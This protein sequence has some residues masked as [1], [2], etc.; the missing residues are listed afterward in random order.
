MKIL[1]MAE[2]FAPFVGGIETM[3]EHLLL[4]LA[5]QGHEICI[6]TSHC[7]AELPDQ[8]DWHGIPLYRLHMLTSL[9]KADIRGILTARAQLRA[10]KRDFAPD[11]AH[12]QFSGPSASFHWDTQDGA[13]VPTVVTI[14]SVAR[15]VVQKRSLFLDTMHNADWIAPVS[16]HMLDWTLGHAP[17]IADHASVVYNGIPGDQVPV[18]PVPLPFDPPCILWI[19]RMVGWKRV[20]RLIDAFAMLCEKPCNARLVL[21]GDGPERAALQARVDAAGLAD[22]V[23]FTGWVD[24]PARARLLE[25]ATLVAIPSQ[26]DENLPM[27]ALEAAGHGRPIAGSAVSGLPEIVEDGASGLLLPDITPASLAGAI[28]AIMSDPVSAQAM[29]ARARAIVAQRFSCSAM[30]ENYLAIYR[31]IAPAKT[32]PETAE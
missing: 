22:R 31:R 14:H 26:A 6:V 10:I 25:Q 21:A 19:G 17:G 5:D 13:P 7:D 1:Y 8:E 4:A 16:Q 29:G 15:Q 12:I 9:A 11:L 32:A 2:R 30:V 18:A 28:G 20:D 23:E 27:A 3:S 24:A